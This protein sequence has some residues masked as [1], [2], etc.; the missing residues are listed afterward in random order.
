MNFG[1]YMESRKI[2]DAKV[3]FKGTRE[4]GI[5]A[6]VHVKTEIGHKAR[7]IVVDLPDEIKVSDLGL[8]NVSG[9]MI[10]IYYRIDSYKYKN[11]D[12]M[13]IPTDFGQKL[14]SLIINA[15]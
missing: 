10:A 12:G 3:I 4:N 14:E 15:L 5:V 7:K 2:Y 1:F 6:S 13:Y 8:H 11:I 9:Q